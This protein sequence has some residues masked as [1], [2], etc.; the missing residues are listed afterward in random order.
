MTPPLFSINTGNRGFS[1]S[2]LCA[3]LSQAASGGGFIFIVQEIM[4]SVLNSSKE[5]EYFKFI[6]IL[7]HNFKVCA[8]RNSV[9]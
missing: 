8:E 2:S 6:L 5:S 3:Q 9:L 4:Y 7:R 1:V